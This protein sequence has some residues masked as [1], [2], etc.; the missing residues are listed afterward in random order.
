MENL[1]PFPGG[2]NSRAHK[3]LQLVWAL[4][5]MKTALLAVIYFSRFFR[6]LHPSPPIDHPVV[7]HIASWTNRNTV[8]DFHPKSSLTVYKYSDF[9]PRI[10][11]GPYRLDPGNTQVASPSIQLTRYNV[12]DNN[13]V[14]HAKSHGHNL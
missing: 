8:T 4:V 5:C 2:G 7:D 9:H 11:T 14:L 6:Q 13:L 1:D 3:V 12:N 10:Q